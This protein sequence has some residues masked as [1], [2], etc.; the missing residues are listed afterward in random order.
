MSLPSIH[1]LNRTVYEIHPGQTFFRRPLTHPDNMGE[2]NTPTALKGKRDATVTAWPTSY[3]HI[4]QD[5]RIFH[6]IEECIHHHMKKSVTNFRK[7]LE[8][9]LKLAITLRH[10][11]TGETYSS[12]QLVGHTKFIPQVRAILTEF[13]DKYLHCPDSPGGGEVQKQMECPPRCRCHLR[14]EYRHEEALETRQ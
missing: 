11:A 9:G 1:F 14:E 2:N 6:L 12:L 4:S 13:Q 5:T 3:T 10:L 7:P 8:V